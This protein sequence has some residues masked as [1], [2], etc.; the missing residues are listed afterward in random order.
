M[1]QHITEDQFLELDDRCRQIFLCSCYDLNLETTKILKIE[2]SDKINRWSIDWESYE[3]KD[4]DENGKF[5]TFITSICKKIF[6]IGKMKEFLSTFADID[7][8]T[9]RSYFNGI[10]N[11][12][13]CQVEIKPLGNNIGYNNLRATEE[14]DALWEAMK[15]AIRYLGRNMD[16]RE[17]ME[18]HET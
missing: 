10:P 1:K 5:S 17:R 11:L 7:V 14:C 3:N 15:D 13:R 2:K 6:T 12:R 16:S 9:V 8:S 4:L 18:I